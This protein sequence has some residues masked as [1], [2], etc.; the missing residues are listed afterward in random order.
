[1]TGI[2]DISGC[3]ELLTKYIR[4]E[5]GCSVTISA[6]YD[7][8]KFSVYPLLKITDQKL[9]QVSRII[10][11][12]LDGDEKVAVLQQLWIKQLGTG[13][14]WRL[15]GCCVLSASL[16]SPWVNLLLVLAIWY[17]L[18]LTE[19]ELHMTDINCRNDYIFLA[20]LSKYFSNKM[21]TNLVFIE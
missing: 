12:L 5:L 8:R 11:S 15:T 14:R 10:G 3:C 1:M 7:P 20:S 9:T 13:N 16:F 19:R 21:E 2:F 18:Y 17:N 6:I 4:A